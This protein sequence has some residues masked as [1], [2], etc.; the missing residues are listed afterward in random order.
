LLS[1]SSALLSAKK[2]LK[3]AEASAVFAAEWCE[4][5]S[6]FAPSSEPAQQPANSR[7]VSASLRRAV[8]RRDQGRCSFVSRDGRPC[9]SR[10]ALEIDH[11]TP[12]AKGGLT[13]FKNLMLLCRSHNQQQAV[14]QIGADV[15]R[16]YLRDV[17]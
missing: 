6:G 10:F 12:I 5:F 14:S 9:G 7:F 3:P 2:I 16:A 11:R 17:S 4:F 1:R 13:T 8:W 15:V